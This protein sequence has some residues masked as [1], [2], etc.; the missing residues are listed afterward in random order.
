MSPSDRSVFVVANAVTGL[1]PG[2]YR[3]MGEGRFEL[4]VE[5]ELRREAGSS[6]W[7]SGSRRR[8]RGRVPHGGPRRLPRAL[9]GR[10]YR[11]AQLQAAVAAGRLYLG[12]YA[13][14]LGASGITFY[15]DAVS[16]FPCPPVEPDARGGP[17]T[18][19]GPPLHHPLP[20]GADTTSDVRLPEPLLADFSRS[21]RIRP[22]SGP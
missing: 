20:R 13:Q 3:Y 10:G 7:S 4:R 2:A 5:S 14:C 1:E 11:V 12:A 6:A 15:D 22:W 17:R 19:G 16:E 8:R 21:I 18:R 9:G